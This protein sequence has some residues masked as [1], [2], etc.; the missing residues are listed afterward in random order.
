MVL[1]VVVTGGILTDSDYLAQ[2]AA[3]PNQVAIG[4]LLILLASLAL[5]MVPVMFWPVGKRYNET[6]AM[7]YIVFRGAIETVLYIVGAL[8]WLLPY[9][10]ST[11]P[12]GG[13]WR[14][15]L[16]ARR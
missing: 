5:A 12:D 1:S 6:L 2:V 4:A 11:E 13:S 15:R 3:Q 14:L 10:L 9:A 7:G 16:M 8:C